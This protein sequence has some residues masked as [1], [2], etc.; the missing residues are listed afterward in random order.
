LFGNDIGGT[1]FTLYSVD[2]QQL[3]GYLFTKEKDVK[4]I[5]K[6]ELGYLSSFYK[7]KFVS[8]DES[9]E[10]F[11]F[12]INGEEASKSIFNNTYKD[13]TR[14]VKVKNGYQLVNNEGKVF[15]GKEVLEKLPDFLRKHK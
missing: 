12:D 9:G 8:V 14:V 3:L 10:N 7:N 15:L 11:W 6:E 13:G 5:T 2:D 4:I 1:V